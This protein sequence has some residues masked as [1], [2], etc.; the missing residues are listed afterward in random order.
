MQALYALT[1]TL[2][3][4][5]TTCMVEP[6]PDVLVAARARGR[7]RYHKLIRS[8]AKT[9]TRGESNNLEEVFRAE[10]EWAGKSTEGNSVFAGQN[11]MSVIY[12]LT[13][14]VLSRGDA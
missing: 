11:F 5:V 14:I 13:E 2:T 3:K 1:D 6:P 8:A 12:I 9:M 10:G 4:Y 7:L